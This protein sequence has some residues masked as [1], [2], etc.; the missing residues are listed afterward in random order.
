M[1]ISEVD[2]KVIAEQLGAGVTLDTD[3]PFNN[4]LSFADVQIEGTGDNTTVTWEGDEVVGQHDGDTVDVANAQIYF[5]DLQSQPPVVAD[6]PAETSVTLED[7]DTLRITSLEI[8][9]EVAS[10]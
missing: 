4:D 7:Q 6:L 2:N 8:E 9:S 1:P 3:G 5:A 10:A